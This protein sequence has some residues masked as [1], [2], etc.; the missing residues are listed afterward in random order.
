MNCEMVTKQLS[1]WIDKKLEPTQQQAISAHINECLECRKAMFEKYTINTLRAKTERVS[2]PSALKSRIV[3]QIDSI[4]LPYLFWKKFTGLFKLSP[5]PIVVATACLVLIVY[6]FSPM[7]YAKPE[8]VSN[9]WVAQAALSCHEHNSAP[10]TGYDYTEVDPTVL[11]QKVNNS[12]KRDFQVA[13]PSIDTST[14]AIHGCRFCALG[15]KPSVYLSMNR[16]GHDISLEIVNAKDISI[17]KAK[18]YEIEGVQ[19]LK[20]SGNNH[21]ILIWKNADLLYVMTSD[22]P[23]DKLTSIIHGSSMAISTHTH[24]NMI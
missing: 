20:A 14:Y 5:V 4:P 3:E 7:L 24:G 21:N 1:A 17:P 18:T 16:E 2:A 23:E 13:L 9:W 12:Q 22:L 19:Y 8:V 11:V 6:L 15:E 10:L